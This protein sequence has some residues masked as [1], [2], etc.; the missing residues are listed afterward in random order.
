MHKICPDLIRNVAFISYTVS[1]KPEIDI[2]DYIN[3]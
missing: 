1:E 2:I 3:K